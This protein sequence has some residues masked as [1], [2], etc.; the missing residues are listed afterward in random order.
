MQKGNHMHE[1]ARIKHASRSESEPVSLVTQMMT[2]SL[3]VMVKPE[4]DTE[5]IV[6]QVSSHPGS[7]RTARMDGEHAEPE[8]SSA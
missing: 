2:V 3:S 1:A 5:E 8:R 7:W 6:T 4:I